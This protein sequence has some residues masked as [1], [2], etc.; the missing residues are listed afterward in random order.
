MILSTYETKNATKVAVKMVVNKNESDTD[1]KYD[2]PAFSMGHAE[3][4]LLRVVI[5]F[6]T[7]NNTIAAVA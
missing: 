5:S 6:A 4:V 7:I 3:G 2:S 1:V